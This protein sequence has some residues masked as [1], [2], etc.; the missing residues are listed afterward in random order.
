M[1][2]PCAE[3]TPVSTRNSRAA[4]PRT[5]PARKRDGLRISGTS[6]WVG[7]RR[8]PLLRYYCAAQAPAKD[9]PRGVGANAGGLCETVL[10]TWRASPS[11]GDTRPPWWNKGKD[12]GV[13]N[14]GALM[15]IRRG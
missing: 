4:S 3:A 8:Q 6:E 12:V 2:C 10:G 7:K 13:Y 9:D 5:G 15:R 11:F 14:P 1:N